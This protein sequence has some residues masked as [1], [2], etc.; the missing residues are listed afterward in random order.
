MVLHGGKQSEIWDSDTPVT[1][2][3]S[4]FDLVVFKIIFGGWGVGVGSVF[5]CTCLKMTYNSKHLPV[6]QTA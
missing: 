5:Q 4:T 6:E 2:I 3:W 1:H